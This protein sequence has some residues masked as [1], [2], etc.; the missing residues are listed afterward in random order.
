MVSR[1]VPSRP[2]TVG[3]AQ[4]SG[5]GIG[6]PAGSGQRVVVVQDVRQ[7][8]VP[9]AAALHPHLRVALE[10]ANMVGVVAVLGDHPELVA[11]QPSMSGVR[12]R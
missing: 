12:R 11:D 1:S 5:P 4:S 7:S 8:A 2:A 10:V 6:Q 9:A 3:S